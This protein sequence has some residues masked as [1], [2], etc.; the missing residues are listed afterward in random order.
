MARLLGDCFSKGLEQI[1]TSWNKPGVV[2]E[3]F[4]RIMGSG[5]HTPLA[6]KKYDSTG[7]S[8]II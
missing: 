8:D 4:D 6:P 3:I 5:A 1:G 2:L 7:K